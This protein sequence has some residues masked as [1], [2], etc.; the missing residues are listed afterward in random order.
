MKRSIEL[1]RAEY[2]RLNDANEA[3][4]GESEG[5]K[6]NLEIMEIKLNQAQQQLSQNKRTDYGFESINIKNMDILNATKEKLTSDLTRSHD[7]YNIKKLQDKLIED[8]KGLY[9]NKEIKPT[10]N[11]LVNAIGNLNDEV[12]MMNN[13]TAKTRTRLISINEIDMDD[14]NDDILIVDNNVKDGRLLALEQIDDVLFQNEAIKNEIKKLRKNS[15]N[16][17]VCF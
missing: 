6:S 14:K 7:I 17:N 2:E 12:S 4:I 15:I 5:L 10:L 1:L 8:N 11:S 13:E 16:S 3:V 9:I